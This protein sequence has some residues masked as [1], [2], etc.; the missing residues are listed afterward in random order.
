MCEQA[1]TILWPLLQQYQFRL[2]EVDIA[3]DDRLIEQY[4]VRIP[5]LGAEH[6]SEE[7]SWPFTAEQVGVFFAALTKS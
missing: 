4:G 1:K 7:L 3:D 6:C 5:V 2:K